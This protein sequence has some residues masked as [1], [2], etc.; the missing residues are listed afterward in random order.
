MA[1]MRKISIGLLCIGA[2]LSVT[3]GAGIAAQPP[4]HAPEGF[5]DAGGNV[6]LFYR[7]VG[8]GRDTI[9]VLHGGPGFTSA[10]LAA[11]LE[12]LAA[13]HVVIFYDQRGAGRST[14]VSD[15]AALDARRFADDL[16]AIRRHFELG[17][18]T[19]LGH[20]WGAAVAA[21]Y[22]TRYPERVQRLILVGA[23][24]ARETQLTAAFQRLDARRDSAT[25]QR[26]GKLRAARLAD[27]GNADACRAYYAVWFVA[28]FADS[29]ALR[30]SRGDFCAGTAEALSNKI[31]HVDRVTLK[32]LGSWDWRLALGAVGAPT[33]VIHGTSD[34]MSV[35]SAREWAS[36][37]RDGRVLLLD[38]SGHFPYLESPDRFFGAVD[39]F[40]GGRWPSGAQP[41]SGKESHRRQRVDFGALHQLRH[42]DELVRAMRDR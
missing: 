10:Y 37:V 19:L 35:E 42:R 25:Q 18:L 29:T 38:R 34:F 30:R 32:S 16:D 12:P 3:P 5:V 17:R 28:A 39:T 11:D 8:T 2:R 23:I 15:S 27:P 6:R 26:L 13:R 24:P 22:A 36:S 21:L 41:V 33:L 9:V 4:H 40:L 14:L 7:I 31:D 20:S 1:R